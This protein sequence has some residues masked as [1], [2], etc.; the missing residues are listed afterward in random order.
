MRL[1]SRFVLAY[2]FELG[3]WRGGVGWPPLP[4]SPL[5][6]CSALLPG[7]RRT[8]VLFPGAPN[9]GH[10]PAGWLATCRRSKCAAAARSGRRAAILS[11]WPVNARICNSWG[12]TLAWADAVVFESRLMFSLV[13]L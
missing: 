3:V 8:W 13:P 6:A 9:G 2:E 12:T 11:R 5:P 10:Q 1:Q 4:P 7:P